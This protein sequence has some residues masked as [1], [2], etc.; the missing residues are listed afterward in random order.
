MLVTV[1][2]YKRGGAVF[3]G[4]NSWLG[5]RN[6]AAR[7]KSTATPKRRRA[8]LSQQDVDGV[9]KF[10]FFI[11]YARSG[12][13]IIGSMMDAHPNM[14]IANECGT[15]MKWLKGPQELKL[16]KYDFFN[17]LYNCSVSSATTGGRSSETKR[18]KG[19]SLAL[20]SSWQGRFTKL[21]VI[22]NKKA[23]G[24]TNKYLSSS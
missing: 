3:N 2:E 19:Y 1:L 7:Q 9:E 4:I 15:F 23:A 22:G 8:N 14:I 21:R 5:E 10:V 12:S 6:A 13:S 16:N 11:G 18:R 24:T 17:T 20:P